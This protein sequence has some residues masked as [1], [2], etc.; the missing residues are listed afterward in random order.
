M[1]VAQSCGSEGFALMKKGNKSMS[2]SHVEQFIKRAMTDMGMLQR[3]SAGAGSL[4]TY[5]DLCVKEAKSLGY[6][7]TA[8]EATNYV[9]QFVETSK[10][11]ELSDIQ[12][13]LVAGGK[14][15]FQPP[16]SGG[17]SGPPTYSGGKGRMPPAGGGGTVSP[18]PSFPPVGLPPGQFGGKRR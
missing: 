2:S 17:G 5:V 7:F 9:K 8:A 16:H 12:L 14:S 4:E 18:P 3:L 1:P 6:D 13:E 10:K 15:G 11:G